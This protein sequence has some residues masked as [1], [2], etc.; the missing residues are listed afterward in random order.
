MILMT[1]LFGTFFIGAQEEPQTVHSVIK[2]RKSFEWYT[3]QY[4]LWEKE[5]KKNKKNGEAWINLYTAA[6]MA[7]LSAQENEQT[8]AWHKTEADVIQKMG[9]SIKGT[10]EYYSLLA[11]YTNVWEAKD[12]A[13]EDKI[14]GYSLKAFE[15]KP[16]SPDVYPNLM[17]I[18]EISRPN[19]KKQKEL[20]VL[21]KASGD[22]TPKLMALSYNALMNTKKN[23]ILLT[24]GDNDT[25]PLWIVQHADDYRNDVNVWNVYLLSITDYRNR[26]FAENGIPELEGQIYETAKIVEHIIKHKGGRELYFYNKGIVASDTSIFEKLYNVGVIYQYSEQSFNN[27]ALIVDHFENKFIVDQ[28]KYDYYISEFAQKDKD[29]GYAYLPGLVSLYQHYDLVGNKEKAET[30]KSIILHLG[31]DFAKLEDIKQEIG[32]D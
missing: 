5:V 4:S 19:K 32:L 31:E 20:S 29:W 14:I 12:K 21:W 6:R 10:Y 9:K 27:S 1:I 15:L 22:H 25:Y 8:M 7:R 13:E 23:A 26:V 18:Y 16:N 24:G 30:T 17:N 2:E 28:L 11:W 3:N